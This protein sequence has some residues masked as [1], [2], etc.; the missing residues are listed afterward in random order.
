MKTV[1]M[2]KKRAELLGR[3]RDYGSPSIL[4][5]ATLGGDQEAGFEQS[6]ASLAFTYIQDKAP[7]LLDYMV[8]FQL[9]DRNE[10]NTKAVG[11]FG[12]QLGKQWLYAP[13]FF[14]NGDLKGHELLYLR[15]QDT[16]VPLK[17][18]W[19]N[20]ILSR[21]PQILGEGSHENQ[22][23][24]GMR[25]PNLHQFSTPPLGGKH[26][27]VRPKLAPWAKE[28]M[29]LIAKMVAV[30]PSKKHASLANRLNL[31]DFLVASGVDGLK[32]AD[33]IASAY[34][35]LRVAL[36][37]SIKQAGLELREQLTRP[38]S[39]LSERL[40]IKE[41]KR[42]F[43][44]TVLAT[45]EPPKPMKIITEQT[46]TANIS[47][48]TD[49]ERE[50]LLRDGYLI[51]DPRKGEEVSVAYNTQIECA[52]TNPDDTDIYEVLVRPGGFE[53]CLVIHHPHT[54]KGRLD[55][56]LVMSVSS[57][58]WENQYNPNLFVKQQD[59]GKSAKT[60][61]KDWFDGLS[62]AS[63]AKDGT[64]L[65]VTE[66]GDGTAVFTAQEKLG[67]DCWRVNWKDY[68]HESRPEYLPKNRSSIGCCDTPSWPGDDC[69]Y[70]NNRP[71]SKM[72]AVQGQLYVPDT[73]KVIK[74]AD[75]PK[76]KRCDK[77]RDDCDCDYFKDDYSRGS[78][79]R[80]LQSGNL[81]DLQLQL[82][83]KTAS[84]KIW[85]DH[86]EV[87]VNE[88]RLSKL[89]GL[90]HLVEVHGL[91][92]KQAVQMIK[93]SERLGGKRYRIKYANPYPMYGGELGPYA[94]GDGMSAPSFPGA[95][96]GMDPAYGGVQTMLPQEEMMPVDGMSSG[97]VDQSVYDPMQQIDPASM[98]VAQQAQQTGQ[99]EVFDTAMISSMLKAVRN[100]SLVDRYIGD[101]VKA[102]DRLGRI[103]FMFYWH[104][105]EFTD[106]YGKQDIPEL[107]DTLRNSFE[108]LGDLVLF[109]K[110][111][112]IDSGVSGLL[113]EPDIEDA[114][115]N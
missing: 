74:I 44:K 40:E 36:A 91:R 7:A 58:D 89:G 87:I 76:C 23:Q 59:N 111:K 86:N 66:G 78:D 70:F 8:G 82:V 112:T 32:L 35:S 42:Q 12:F 31:K 19:V 107:E 93:E 2:Q 109:L 9:V 77:V 92:E 85:H 73:C 57:K 11:I 106:R 41:A 50:K 101:L 104:S 16:F 49:S 97:N 95:E 15:N 37:D 53:K 55:F 4:K 52:L 5:R 75:P 3:L 80:V 1:T 10:D 47:E 51:K 30:S 102:L 114:A 84:L 24:L 108:V 110:E 27:H 96:Y 103:L 90:I 94:A 39:V 33:S 13:V 63:L 20:K 45:A 38:K 69:I 83:Q 99:K 14:M 60:V 21:K 17:E 48:M 43:R 22:Q 25:E 105:E 72:R 67:D 29:P 62:N 26:A 6:F 100:D 115:R 54:N 113:G 18:N 64:Y 28:A 56:A 98:Q 61:W 46:I 81:D 88:K 79:K 34:P 65:I 71:G 68:C